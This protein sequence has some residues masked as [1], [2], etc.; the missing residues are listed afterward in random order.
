MAR[1]RGLTLGL[2]VTLSLV[3]GCA[4][5]KQR[6]HGGLG[7]LL[8]T[9]YIGP[10]TGYGLNEGRG[11]RGIEYFRSIP[12]IHVP[13]TLIYAYKAYGGDTALRLA[14]E[15]HI[16]ALNTEAETLE[17][18]DMGLKAGVLDREGYRQRLSELARGMFVNL[19]TA[20]RAHD[21]G[22]ISPETYKR[23][24]RILMEQSDHVLYEPNRGL[25]KESLQAEALSEAAYRKELKRLVKKG[26]PSFALLAEARDAG[27][28]TDPQYRG[29]VKELYQD[30]FKH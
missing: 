4:K 27:V 23:L 22:A 14:Y 18:L 21:E 16:D 10:R 28:I 19:R 29:K 9:I 1:S 13:P 17:V 5:P 3:A 12:L 26:Y 30:V 8:A 25:L 7:P 2:C 15:S 6:G 24:L 20:K 11:L